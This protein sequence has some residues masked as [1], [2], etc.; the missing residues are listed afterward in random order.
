MYAK[1]GKKKLHIH[2][3]HNQEL[4]HV[5]LKTAEYFNLI[6]LTSVVL[7]LSQSCLVIIWHVNCHVSGGNEPGEDSV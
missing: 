2:K 1:H 6:G 4:Q 3:M 7:S 5:S